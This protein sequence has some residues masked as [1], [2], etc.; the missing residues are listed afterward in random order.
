MFELIS[1]ITRIKTSSK[2]DERT[3]RGAEVP[4][5]LLHNIITILYFQMCFANLVRLA[6]SSC[7][8]MI[9]YVADIIA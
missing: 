5:L 1:L 4:G 7:C 8:G 9:V 3:K 2:N 6:Y